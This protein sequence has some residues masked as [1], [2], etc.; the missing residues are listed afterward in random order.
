M[1]DKITMTTVDFSQ[2]AMGYFKTGEGASAVRALLIDGV[3]SVFEA[4]EI[5]ASILDTAEK[6][7]D[8]AKVAKCLALVVQD[9]GEQDSDI[10]GVFTQFII[11]RV[12]DRW[13]G[14]T[15]IRAIREAI[16]AA[17]APD[18]ELNV[19][20][21]YGR[22]LFDSRYIGRTGLRYDESY[23]VNYEAITIRATCTRADYM[24]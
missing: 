9:A 8:T 20:I 17:F 19:T 2:V 21:G 6:T 4:G 13:C 11:V 16:E 12:Y 24:N 22:G 7:R 18:K 14:Y 10:A 5:T 15:N 3:D 1:W 23:N